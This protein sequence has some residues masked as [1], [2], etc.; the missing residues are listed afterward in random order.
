MAYSNN[1]VI[2][3]KFQGKLGKELV[4]RNW[5][6]K[7][8][9]AK[10]P[11]RRKAAPTAEQVKLQDQFLMGSR[12]AKAVVGDADPNLAEAYMAVLRPRQNL[13][14]RALEDFMSAPKVVSINTR[15]YQGLIGDK[16]V[17][18]AKDDF[19]VT[20]VKVEIYAADGS[21]LEQ[22]EAVSDIYDL[23][24]TYTATQNNSLL[25]GT[26]IKAIATDIPNN[27]GIL[28]AVL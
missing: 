16:I 25:A 11:G 18:R 26:T 27:E 13:Y 19:R 4:F 10:A 12:Y 6:G 28:E 23:D 5:D 3:G 15:A 1:S 14:S 7:T 21:L 22:G 2:T 20:G 8:I 24:W 9:V 17:V